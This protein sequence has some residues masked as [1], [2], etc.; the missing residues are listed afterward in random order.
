MAWPA[1]PAAST[2]SGTAG[3]SAALIFLACRLSWLDEKCI[4]WTYKSA[5]GVA[6]ELQW[7]KPSNDPAATIGNKVVSL[8]DRFDG[9]FFAAEAALSSGA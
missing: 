1:S 5:T 8:L 2:A 6:R 9:F 7:Q 3:N 4:S